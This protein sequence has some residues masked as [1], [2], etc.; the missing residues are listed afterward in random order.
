[1]EI[2]FFYRFLSEIHVS[3]REL[4]YPR[5]TFKLYRRGKGEGREHARRGILV[6]EYLNGA[7]GPKREREREREREKE[8]ERKE[9]RKA[10]INVFDVPRSRRSGLLI[11][12]RLTACHSNSTRMNHRTVYFILFRLPTNSF[13]DIS[14]LQISFCLLYLYLYPIIY[15]S[16]LFYNGT[17][18]SIFPLRDVFSRSSYY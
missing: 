2:A 17:E 15:I 18:I 14:N 9:E 6:G 12:R 8:K 11:P 7:W 4:T 13:H 16:L 5:R 10:S 1:M 3:A